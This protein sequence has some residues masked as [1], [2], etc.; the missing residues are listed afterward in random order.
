MGCPWA[1]LVLPE[2]PW[3]VSEAPERP[4]AAGL[5]LR[6]AS[7]AGLSVATL[8]ERPRA[9][10]AARTSQ[11]P[12]LAQGAATRSPS[13]PQGGGQRVSVAARV[14]AAVALQAAGT[15]RSGAAPEGAGS[16]PGTAGATGGRAEALRSQRARGPFLL[17]SVCRADPGC[18]AAGPA[19]PSPRWG[20]RG[21][22]PRAAF[23]R[24]GFTA[25]GGDRLVRPRAAGKAGASGAGWGAMEP[26]GAG[27]ATVAG[28]GERA[29]PGAKNAPRCRAGPGGGRALGPATRPSG[30]ATE[31]LCPSPGRSLPAWPWPTQQRPLVPPC[32]PPARPAA[33]PPGAVTLSPPP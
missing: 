13:H 16:S 9:E 24:E 21:A 28:C 1:V 27:P 32:P 18:P 17:C 26:R 3:T 30:T 20:R 6:C 23:P 10:G 25:E 15:P 8:A 14:S 11:A 22:G 19:R 12:G 31:P 33:P 2:H 5:S 4:S 29:A 7:S